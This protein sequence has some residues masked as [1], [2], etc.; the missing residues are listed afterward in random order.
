MGKISSGKKNPPAF[1]GR[2][3]FFSYPSNP[4]G[5]L[6]WFPFSG[7]E[8]RFWGYNEAGFSPLTP[9]IL[10]AKGPLGV[11]LEEIGFAKVKIPKKCR[12]G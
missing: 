10:S 7:Y 12:G 3:D 2:R 4:K 9:E 6:F 8:L 1:L 5:K 11:N